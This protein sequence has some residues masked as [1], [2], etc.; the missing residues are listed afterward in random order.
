MISSG[1]GME[2]AIYF[3]KYSYKHTHTHTHAHFLGVR[4]TCVANFSL[5]KCVI[6]VS[7]VWET[8]VYSLSHKTVPSSYQQVPKTRL[9]P[10]IFID[11]GEIK[12]K[13]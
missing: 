2:Y 4:L 7:K 11:N 5:E 6:Q 10:A 13:Q 3:G 9:Y 8:L 1:R 12:V